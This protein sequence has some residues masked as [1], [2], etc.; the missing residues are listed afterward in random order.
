MYNY[1]LFV[2]PEQAAEW[3]THSL[4]ENEIEVRTSFMK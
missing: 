1:F 3:M 4:T 2:A